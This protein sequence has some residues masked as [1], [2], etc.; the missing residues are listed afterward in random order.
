MRSALVAAMLL[1]RAPHPRA[2]P[3]VCDKGVCVHVA[4]TVTMEV[5]D[6]FD[7]LALSASWS[8]KEQALKPAILFRDRGFPKV[9]L[10]VTTLRAPHMLAVSMAKAPDVTSFKRLRAAM[11]DYGLLILLD[12]L[13]TAQRW[14]W[15][16]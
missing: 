5:V 12:F 11:D 4:S 16:S 13:P 14:E 3:R 2:P 1:P 10:F 7:A 6:P 9:L 15:M 8:P